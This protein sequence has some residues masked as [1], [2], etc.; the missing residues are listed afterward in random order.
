ML[1]SMLNP[2]ERADV[3][4]VS[5]EPAMSQRLSALGLAKGTPVACLHKSLSG[6]ICAYQI[7]DAVIAMRRE[8]AASVAV[9]ICRNI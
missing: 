4:K 7:R 5:A 6:N 8:T 1:L 2:G 3:V 9:D